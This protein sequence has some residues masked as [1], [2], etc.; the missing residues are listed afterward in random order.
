M[1]N[2][3]LKQKPNPTN[4]GALVVF[5]TCKHKPTEPAQGL[6]QSLGLTAPS[7]RKSY[8]SRFWTG[9][10]WC[11]ANTPVVTLCRGCSYSS[12]EL[13]I[14]WIFNSVTLMCAENASQTRPHHLPLHFMHFLNRF[15]YLVL[16]FQWFGHLPSG[17]KSQWFQVTAVSGLAAAKGLLQGRAQVIQSF[18]P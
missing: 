16:K 9:Q 5:S 15:I 14:P 4:L 1:N 7:Q 6:W 13:G 11:T 3:C 18:L 2:L 17:F 12:T 10:L 8:S